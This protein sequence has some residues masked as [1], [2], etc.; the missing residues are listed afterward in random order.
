M[1]QKRK[2]VIQGL[3]FPGRTSATAA[4]RWANRRYFSS[5]TVSFGEYWPF[6]YSDA[7][8]WNRVL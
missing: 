7:Y 4:R 8:I 3:G 1:F 5:T 6:W 2:D